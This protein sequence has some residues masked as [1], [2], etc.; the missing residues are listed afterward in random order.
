[1]DHFKD[2]GEIVDCQCVVDRNTGNCKGFA[3]ITFMFPENALTAYKEFDGK[4]I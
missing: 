4:I 2:F 1:M 3:V